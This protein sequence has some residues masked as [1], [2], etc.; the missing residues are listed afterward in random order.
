MP[1]CDFFCSDRM[2]ERRLSPK[3]TVIAATQAARDTLLPPPHSTFANTIASAA[4]PQI[5]CNRIACILV[6][7][8]PLAA[9]IRQSPELRDRPL[10]LI[11]SG[12]R[13]DAA[14]IANMECRFVSAHAR[15]MGVRAGMTVARARAAAAGLAVMSRSQVAE[16]SAA[17]ALVD[18]ALSFSPLV[19]AGADG[20]VYLDLGGLER[21][22]QRLRANSHRA[23]A[24]AKTNASSSPSEMTES[25]VETMD[26]ETIETGLAQ[27][28]LGRVARLG[29]DAAVGIASS[30]EVAL[31]AARCGGARPIAAGREEEFLTWLPLDLLKLDGTA[32]G[33]GR[34]GAELEQTLARWGIRRLGELA[35]LDI[36][37]VGSRLGAR[38]VELIRIARG[39]CR[40]PLIARR[41]AENFAEAVELEWGVDSLEAMG[42]VMRAMIERVVERLQLRG[43]AAGEIAL[44]LELDGRRRDVRRV[45]LPAPTNEARTLLALILL[46]LESAPPAAA[47]EAIRITVEPRAPGAAQAD[48]FAPPCPTPERLHVTLARLAALCGPGKVGTLMPRNSHLPDAIEL[49]PFAPRP[50]VTPAP[51]LAQNGTTAIDAA[52]SPAAGTT[53][54][55]LAIRAVR[56]PH[57]VEVLCT[58][59]DAPEFVRGA[60][61][62]GRVV[63]CAGPWRIAAAPSHSDNGGGDHHQGVPGAARDYYDVALE[64]G[65]V[66]RLLC[67]LRSGEW[68]VD[69]IYD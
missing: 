28:A 67:D 47:V 10:V 63:S 60:D 9:A 23:G 24:S 54:A 62:G 16:A 40:T 2:I 64:D 49:G 58:R 13:R 6:A 30:K 1:A 68:Y 15:S 17:E 33:G 52:R 36:R 3:P 39:E 20:E 5:S 25:P 35:R 26:A 50:A 59:G 12:G 56:P 61:F 65:G 27:E 41:A 19:E 7:D 66:Y 21:L 69:G 38:A 46:N 51:T 34:D 42:F 8:F 43:M 11:E 45:A 31:L 32:G 22:H 14:G 53:V 29:M 57:Q 48:M 44:A 37:A 55:Q 18:V 4:S